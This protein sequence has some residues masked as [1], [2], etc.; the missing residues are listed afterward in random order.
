VAVDSSWYATIV[1]NGN[2]LVQQPVAF[3]PLYLRIPTICIR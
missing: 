1:D 3:Y 2:D